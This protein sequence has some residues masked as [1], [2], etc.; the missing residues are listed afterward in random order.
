MTWLKPQYQFYI[1]LFVVH[2]LAGTPRVDTHKC[3][4]TN[5]AH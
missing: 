2:T 3:I 5:V 4:N 1:K